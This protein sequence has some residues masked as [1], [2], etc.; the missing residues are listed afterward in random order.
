M[1][2]AD[3]A[4]RADTPSSGRCL[5]TATVSSIVKKPEPHT[6]A[7]HTPSTTLLRSPPHVVISLS[8]FGF[9]IILYDSCCGKIIFITT[10]SSI[11]RFLTTII[12]VQ[13]VGEQPC[14]S[15][16]KRPEAL[17]PAVMPI[18]LSLMSTYSSV[19]EQMEIRRRYG[20]P[21]VPH[22]RTAVFA[23]GG[24]YVVSVMSCN[25]PPAVIVDRGETVGGAQ[26]PASMAVP[27]RHLRRTTKVMS[28]I[29]RSGLLSMQPMTCS[30][31][32]GFL[33]LLQVSSYHTQLV[34]AQPETLPPIFVRCLLQPG[35]HGNNGVE[36]CCATFISTIRRNSIQ[37]FT[38]ENAVK[39][40]TIIRYLLHIPWRGN[41][42]FRTNSQN[43]EYSPSLA[44][45]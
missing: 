41:R 17:R 28:N 36:G 29:S 18:E 2:G 11:Y 33:V 44:R 35:T 23:G 38:I 14:I 8:S 3:N 1:A 15:G 5:S 16:E 30:P 39:R 10:L 20:V 19:T 34:Q 24:A 9:I 27:R 4:I 22:R 42:I 25:R 43:K 13:S 31:H 45:T 12:L 7:R 40:G 37:S 21:R 26:V 6:R 32:Q